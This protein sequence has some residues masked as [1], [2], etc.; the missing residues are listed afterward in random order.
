MF[1]TLASVMRI[2]PILPSGDCAS[3]LPC[4]MTQLTMRASASTSSAR[5]TSK[6][7]EIMRVAPSATM[8][9]EPGLA[10]SYA[11]LSVAGDRAAPQRHRAPLGHDPVAGANHES[12]P[13]ARLPATA[14]CRV[15]PAAGY[16]RPVQPVTTNVNSLSL[17]V[18]QPCKPG[19]AQPGRSSIGHP[20]RARQIYLPLLIALTIACRVRPTT[21]AASPTVYTQFPYTGYRPRPGGG[22]WFLQTNINDCCNRLG[23]VDVRI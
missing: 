15:L 2:S 14:T 1:A 11:D 21:C 4:W 19:S 9:G 8:T 6:G 17:V 7:S 5:A 23:S 12:S 13:R 20:R 22:S 10:R 16:R 3:A 18:V